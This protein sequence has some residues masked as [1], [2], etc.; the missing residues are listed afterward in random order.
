MAAVRRALPRGSSWTA[1]RS[2][3]SPPPGS[4]PRRRAAAD[5]P[6][7]SWNGSAR[8]IGAGRREPMSAI[9]RSSCAAEPGSVAVEE[10]AVAAVPEEQRRA[11]P[12]EGAQHPADEDGM[13]A[14][15]MRRMGR[16]VEAGEASREQRQSLGRRAGVEP[17]EVAA[18]AREAVAKVKLV[19]REHMDRVVP[20]RGE[21]GEA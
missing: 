13:V 9:S 1:A 3:N 7:R 21:G 10:I 18:R 15:V 14:A 17:G 8:S 16:A 19:G 12:N 5:G 6:P 11:L 2:R 20:G 4:T